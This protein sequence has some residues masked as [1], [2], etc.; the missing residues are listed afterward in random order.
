ME[1]LIVIDDNIGK[2]KSQLKSI[3][4]SKAKNNKT[5]N[6]EEIFEI[7]EPYQEENLNK[8]SNFSFGTKEIKKEKLK[9]EETPEFKL[10]QKLQKEED[11]EAFIFILLIFV[12]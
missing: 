3:L 5:Q 6:E 8:K 1:K 12:F 11:I 4:D 9:F 10:F 7:T 2:L